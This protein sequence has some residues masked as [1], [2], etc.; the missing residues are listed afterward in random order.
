MM[1]TISVKLLLAVESSL[2]VWTSTSWEADRRSNLVLRSFKSSFVLPLVLASVGNGQH[3]VLRRLFSLRNFQ[4]RKHQLQR[5]HVVLES[6]PQA[7]Q[8]AFFQ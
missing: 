4:H 8:L 6:V 5:V 2:L 7:G 3:G 1:P